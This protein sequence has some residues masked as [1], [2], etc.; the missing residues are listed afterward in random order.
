MQMESLQSASPRWVG[1]WMAIRAVCRNRMQGR[2][3]ILLGT[4]ASSLLPDLG[5]HGLLRRE[6]RCA[7]LVVQRE[8]RVTLVS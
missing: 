2:L 6:C 7:S 1:S 4:L 8:A 5:A 3:Y